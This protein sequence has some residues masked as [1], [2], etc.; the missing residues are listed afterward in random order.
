M[1]I[2]LK[3]PHYLFILANPGA[4]GHRLGRIISC[5]D[6]V[7]WYS[8]GRNGY[9][10]WETYIH[11]KVLGKSISEYHYDRYIGERQVPL[12]GKRIEQY[13]LPEDHD[14]FYKQIW[15]KQ[16]RDPAVTKVISNN[17]IHWILHDL[18]EPL[19]VRFPNAKIISLIDDDVNAVV[20][21]YLKTTAKF[22]I[23]YRHIGL[24][25]D[26]ETEYRNKVKKLLALNQ[27]ATEEDFWYFN[28]P[29]KTEKS[30]K[31][32]IQQQLNTCNNLRKKF[33]HPNYLTVKWTNLEVELISNF[34]S[35]KNIDTNY[36][37][38][39]TTDE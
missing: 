15:V 3:H 4:G 32:D 36:T 19:L 20:D 31:K 8:A 23:T 11:D 38:L 17:Y 2:E 12:V 30:F 24:I 22:P 28:N 16:I 25:P 13:W 35:C 18:P 33:Q 29:G 7:Y 6:K 39:L 1:A 9:T 34:L 14:Y 21:R 37:R 10:P 26:Y 27:S 5:F